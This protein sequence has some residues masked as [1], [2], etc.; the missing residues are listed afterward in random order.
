M[1]SNNW[2]AAGS[3]NAAFDGGMFEAVKTLDGSRLLREATSAFISP[4]VQTL[5]DEQ[6]RIEHLARELGGHNYDLRAT[7]ALARLNLADVA[8]GTTS[9]TEAMC[10]HKLH[11]QFSEATKFLENASRWTEIQQTIAEFTARDHVMPWDDIKR[12]TDTMAQ[13]AST[14][15]QLSRICDVDRAL[16]AIMPEPA[17][18]AWSTHLRTTAL[19]TLSFLVQDWSKP[20]G[21]LTDLGRSEL[22]MSVAWLT[23]HHAEPVVMMAAVTPRA[24]AKDGLKIIVEDEVVCAVCRNPMITITSDF[25]WVGPRRGVRQRLIFPK[26]STCAESERQHPGLFD[27]TRRNLTHPVVSIRVIRGGAQGDGRPC[28]ALR[29]VRVRVENWHDGR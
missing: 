3:L 20:L 29:L 9:F 12:L 19:P 4:S 16:R 8:G 18:A 17:H 14:V 25:K 28:G 23:R 1:T 26:C 22:G 10:T 7:A 21:L 15:R 11:S 24:G 2:S 27:E 13:E 6:R 5:L